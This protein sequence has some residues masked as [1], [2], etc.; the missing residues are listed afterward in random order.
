MLINGT[1]FFV[2]MVL[3]GLPAA[4][5]APLG[6]FGGFVSVFIP[7]IGTYIGAAVPILVTLASVGF[8]EA[9]IVLAY[10]LLYQLI[11][12]TWLSRN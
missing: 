2:V 4:L 7:V 5:A 8:A 1:G 12:N 11:E 9:L 10:T 6:L 3:V